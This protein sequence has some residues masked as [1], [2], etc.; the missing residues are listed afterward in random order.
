MKTRRTPKQW[1]A[2]LASRDSF[3]GTNSEFCQRHGL[4]ITSFYKH[5][6]HFRE[7]SS[8]RFVQVKT[9]TEQTRIETHGEVQFDLHSGKLTFPSSLPS[10]QIAA[11]IKGVSQ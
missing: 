1:Q 4:S 10:A 9:T 5:Q 8:T 7:Q 6:A 11:I 2:L 3:S